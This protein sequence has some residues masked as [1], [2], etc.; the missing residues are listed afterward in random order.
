MFY[1]P[2]RFRGL[3]EWR[4]FLFGVVLV[5]MMIFRPQGLLPSRRRAMEMQY[6]GEMHEDRLAEA[7]AD[8]ETPLGMPDASDD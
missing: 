6:A 7:G 2:E 3:A 5:V 1:L 4:F 8:L